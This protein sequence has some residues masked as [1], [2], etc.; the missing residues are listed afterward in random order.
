[1]I[2]VIYRVEVAIPARVIEDFGRDGD[3]TFELIRST[4]GHTSAGRGQ[5]PFDGSPIEWAEFST[6]EAAQRCEIQLGETAAKFT[7]RLTTSP[8]S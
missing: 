3:F 6:P 7:R 4:T 1:V 5:D 8:V 2:Q